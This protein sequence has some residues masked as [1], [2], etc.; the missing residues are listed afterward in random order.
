MVSIS[1]HI[2][3]LK[4]IAFERYCPKPIC[5]PEFQQSKSRSTELYSEQAVSVPA[6]LNANEL[7]LSTPA[8]PA[9]RPSQG[10]DATC[11]SGRMLM[12]YGGSNAMACEDAFVQPNQFHPQLDPEEEAPEEVQTLL[13]QQDVSEWLVCLNML[14]FSYVLLHLLPYS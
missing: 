14:V 12:F 10:D 2:S 9:T 7:R 5:G 13:L 6:P 1:V 3:W 4:D 8:L 11:A